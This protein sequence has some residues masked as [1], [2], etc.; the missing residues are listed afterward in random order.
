MG[1]PPNS[2]ITVF[3]V[4]SALTAQTIAYNPQPPIKILPPVTYPPLGP[5]GTSGPGC[6]VNKVGQIELRA[7]PGQ[8][9][10]VFHATL[11]VQVNGGL[12]WDLI[13]GTFDCDLPSFV[14]NDHV[15]HLNT[16]TGD[17]FAGSASN[18][19][20]AFVYDSP[21]GARFCTRA[22]LAVAFGASAP[23]SGVPGGPID[24]KLCSDGTLDKLAYKDVTTGNIVWA[25]FDRVTGVATVPFVLVNGLSA[26][27][28][29]HSPEPLRDPNGTARAFLLGKLHP[30]NLSDAWY[31]SGKF[32]L[33]PGIAHPLHETAPPSATFLRNGTALGGTVFMP[34]GPTYGDPLKI[35]FMSTNCDVA[36]P[37]GSVLICNFFPYKPLEVY[38][39]AVMLGDLGSSPILVPG[40]N[41]LLGL[42]PAAP[43]VCVPFQTVRPYTGVACWTLRAP[44]GSSG[45]RLSSQSILLAPRAGV[46]LGN[47]SSVVVR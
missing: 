21:T 17:E 2:L 11:S 33:P 6:Q 20:L 30:A 14:K 39:V 34:E 19:L 44:A 37:D 32:N 38:D 43:L 31:G 24:P 3:F 9:P 13:T 8:P 10:N 35:D 22:S 46:F 5:T 42:D 12:T 40:A 25:T 1:R 15:D 7:L 36:A 29:F 26:A 18:D 47:N 41:G 16:T 27:E 4:C 23:I 45:V 28:G